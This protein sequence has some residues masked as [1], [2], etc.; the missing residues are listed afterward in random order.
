MSASGAPRDPVRIGPYRV[1]KRI[2]R[3]GMGVVYLAQREGPLPVRPVALKV[4]RAGAAVEDVLVRFSRERAVLAALDHPN[5]AR[6]LDAGE[7]DTGEPWFA[8]EFVEGLP[9]DDFCDAHRLGVSQRVEL[10]RHICDAVHQAHRNLVIHRDLKPRN[11]LVTADGTPKL[12]D[13]G[14]A[15]LLNPVLAP[16]A[17]AP[18][19]AGMQLMTPEY[20]APEQ[21]RGD[22]ISTA[23]DVYSLGVVLYELLTGR[24][25][26]RFVTRDPREIERVVCEQEAPRPSD[27]VVAP[28]ADPQ[29]LAGSLRGDGS[30][31]P[32]DLAVRRQSTVARLRRRLRGDL[33]TIVAMAL[34]KEPQRR[35]AS[36]EALGQDLRRHLASEPVMA[37]PDGVA[38]RL[39]RFVKRHRGL[40]AAVVAI[41]VVLAGGVAA[42]AWQARRAARERDQ[43]IAAQEAAERRLD[44]V[45]EL[46]RAMLFEW[47]DSIARLRGATEVRQTLVERA[48]VQLDRLREE[49]R[50]DPAL[51]L[52]LAGGHRRLAEIQGGSRG[53]NLGDTGAALAS[54]ERAAEILDEARR[55]GADPTTVDSH[56]AANHL[57]RA[58]NERL[59]GDLAAAEAACRSAV[60]LRE[61]LAAQPGAGDTER[62]NL[63][64]ALATMGDLLEARGDR[65]GA[66][67]HFE[68][69][70]EI[71]RGILARNTG[72]AEAR[73]DLT[74]ALLRVGYLHLKA[75]RPD[76]AVEYYRQML[77]IREEILASS[78]T[79]TARRDVMRARAVLAQALEASG[80]TAEAIESAREALAIAELLAREDPRNERARRDLIV[81]RFETGGLLARAGERGEALTLLRLAIDGARTALQGE[82]ENR[83]L[84]GV[85]L[86]AREALADALRQ[87]AGGEV[88]A[89][90]LYRSALAGMRSDAPPIDAARVRISLASL[91]V[92]RGSLL[93]AGT[94]L[95]QAEGGLAMQSEGQREGHATLVESG[96]LALA[97]GEWHMKRGE[98]E[99]ALVRVRDGISALER[100]ASAFGSTGTVADLIQRLRALCRQLEASMP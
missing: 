83:V 2:A 4:L 67:E 24:R 70:L 84:E 50:G 5:I 82:P 41:M 45:R 20:A 12:L 72:D 30:I 3:G 25:P 96:R 38:Y 18:T 34:R 69:S 37:R 49:S 76:Q 91:L 28:V 68:R 9:V 78:D 56:L 79:A 13:F 61:P 40:A 88:E 42:T 44:Q 22:P 87:E 86:G 23:C 93:E 60:A 89:M 97:R 54:L 92:D 6:L 66:A 63:A 85:L 31:S 81:A 1:L 77:T 75:G 80:R 36:A 73:R 62:R 65:S 33:D 46:V 19:A 11:I 10:F 17:D 59:R 57:L 98:T 52:E 35:Y 94:L 7:S 90:E 47:H 58:D 26:Y 15:K 53:G 14:I 21:V 27:A 32:E 29:M 48:V 16:G 8:M 71:R 99:E 51:L 74:T 43:A 100:H 39:S 64:V 55:A 95:D